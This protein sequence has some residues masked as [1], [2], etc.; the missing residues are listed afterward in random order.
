MRIVVLALALLLG[1][2]AQAEPVYVVEIANFSCGYSRSF[3]T[4]VPAVREAVEA[5]GGRFV[6]APISFGEGQSQWRD[7]VYYASRD[8][9][10]EAAQS[11]RKALF[12][13][14]QTLQLPLESSAQV[15]EHLRGTLGETAFEWE[16]LERRAHAAPTREAVE[17]AFAL[18]AANRVDPL[19]AFLLIVN[20]EVVEKL[21]R[22][23]TENDLSALRDLVLERVAHH[24]AK[25]P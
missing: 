8:Q 6:F 7:R 20:G 1:A 18:G 2:T 24:G 15:I 22:N 16:V 9:G 3:D 14:A 13:G 25:Q 12:Y 23:D 10:A 11:V 5:T 4:S 17:Q 21:D 19:P